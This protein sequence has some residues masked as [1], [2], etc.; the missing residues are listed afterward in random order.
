M[1]QSSSKSTLVGVASRHESVDDI[2]KHNTN[3]ELDSTHDSIYF[4]NY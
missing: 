4:I 3:I 1:N 2:K